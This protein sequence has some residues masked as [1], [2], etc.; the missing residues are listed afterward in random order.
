MKTSIH[1]DGGIEDAICIK[2]K[3]ERHGER[4]KPIADGTI[5]K[6]RKQSDR[7]KYDQS[8]IKGRH[9]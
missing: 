8:G 7:C 9:F 1:N 3:R 6:R 5:Y 2:K 4:R